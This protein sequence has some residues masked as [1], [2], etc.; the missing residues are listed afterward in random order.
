MILKIAKDYKEYIEHMK[1]KDFVIIDPPWNYSY[2]KYFKTKAQEKVNSNFPMEI[3]NLEFLNYIFS[4]I[5]SK[6]I[7][8]WL[9]GTMLGCFF[10]DANK[11]DL[12]KF[13]YKNILIWVR[14]KNNGEKL[15][16]SGFWFKNTCEYLLVFAKPGTSP[17]RSRVS[18]W[19]EEAVNKY[20]LTQKPKKF[21]SDIMRELY[22]D[23]K[24]L[25]SYIFSG[26]F[27]DYDI[28]I[29]QKID[30]VDLCFKKKQKK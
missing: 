10:N 1:E 28:S 2:S 9:P 5:K 6:I 18:N 26:P 16:K 23:G 3:N 11:L 13:K 27:I 30:L 7:F 21:E 19:C 15:S 17:I 25:G 20:A 22:N 12:G 14:T 24:K 8:L 4:K 29:K